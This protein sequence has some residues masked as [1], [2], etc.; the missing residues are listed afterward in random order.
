MATQEEKQEETF[1]TP[2][3]IALATGADPKAV[4]AHLRARYTR[5]LELKGTR[6]QI[7]AD[8]AAAVIEHFEDSEEEDEEVENLE[9]LVS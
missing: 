4:R 6:W 8:I 2:T 5:A 1:V 9:E 3:E 7:P